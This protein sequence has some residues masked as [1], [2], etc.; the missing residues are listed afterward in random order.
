MD[1]GQGNI[2]VVAQE[3]V[4]GDCIERHGTSTPASAPGSLPRQVAKPRLDKLARIDGLHI[5]PT[6]GQA[7]PMRLYAGSPLTDLPAPLFPYLFAT[8]SQRQVS[9]G[10]IL[11]PPD[12]NRLEYLAILEGELEVEHRVIDAEGSESFETGRL[13]K[14]AATQ[15]IVLLHTVPWRSTVRAL[16]AAHVLQLDSARVEALRGW[17]LRCDARRKPGKLWFPRASEAPG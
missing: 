14:S 3:T 8:A 15:A 7:L 10:T 11:V 6:L 4:Q 13:M 16:T 17:M 5:I 1:K 9:P 2:R 12:V